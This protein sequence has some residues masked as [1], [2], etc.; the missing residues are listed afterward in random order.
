MSTT[1]FGIQF[2]LTVTQRLT[3]RVAFQLPPSKM[4]T[5]TIHVDALQVILPSFFYKMLTIV[6][7]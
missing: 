4:P 6:M 1:G 2:T 7:R 3:R 5:R